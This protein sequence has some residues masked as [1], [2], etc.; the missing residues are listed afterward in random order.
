[1]SKKENT[2]DSGTNANDTK[3][4]AE[5]S[6]PAFIQDLMKNGATTL[7]APTREALAEMVDTIPADISYAVGAVGH[8]ADAGVYCLHV[9]LSNEP[10]A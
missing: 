5:G 8:N 2:V 3:Q 9:H 10:N 4:P 6:S 1:M 7:T